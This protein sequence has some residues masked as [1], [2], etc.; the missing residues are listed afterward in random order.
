VPQEG[1]HHAGLTE[2]LVVLD[3]EEVDHQPDHLARREVLAGGL[4]RELREAADEL[5]VEVAHLEVRDDVRVEVDL[6]ELG[7]DQ[8]EQVLLAEARDLCVEAELL[9]HVARRRREA[10]D[11]GA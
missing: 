1:A 6:R 2:Q 9:D 3:E 7:D 5:L 8:V 11:V 4:V 10:G